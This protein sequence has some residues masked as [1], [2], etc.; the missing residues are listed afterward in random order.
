LDFYIYWLG[1]HAVT[2]DAHLYLDQLAAH[3]FT[4]TPFA[5]AMFTPLASIP[6]VIA[7]VMWEVASVG[8]FAWA[9]T[10]TLKLAGY[11]TP[12]IAVA[13]VVVAGLLLEPMWHSL[14]LGQ[15]NLFLLALILADV[16]RVSLGRSAGIGIGIAA[17]IK[18]TPA[19]FVILFLL[20][21]RTKAALTAGVTF[22]ICGLIAYFIAP[23]ASRLYWLH[24]FYDTTRV[25]VPYISNQSPYGAAARILGGVTHLGG[26][27]LL[28][29]LT[30]GAF[31]LT[32]AA[33]WARNN[34][35]LSAAAA[36]GV[37]GLLVSPISWAHHWVWIM[38]ALVLL[39]RD[40]RRAFALCGYL[41]FLLAP[42]W[43][44]PHGDGRE[45]GFHGL[46]TLVANCYL[47][48]GLIFL[49]YLTS[50]LRGVRGTH[51][52]ARPTPATSADA[53]SPVVASSR[54]RGGTPVPRR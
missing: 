43:W 18:L 40:G 10:T 4:N 38:P 19:I 37:T 50:G 24:T 25:G 45:Y 32:V 48:A 36:T 42:L 11:R 47:I 1:G 14:F 30:I 29:P 44:T 54:S 6:L 28:V 41:L 21:R 26:W 33:I 51:V 31:G 7:R 22:V 5:A 16:R 20:T 53:F 17:A 46:L 15:I 23:D 27:Y 34:D 2:Q 13:A 12:R 8:A 3:W 35:W 52:A 39:V 49:V 9:C